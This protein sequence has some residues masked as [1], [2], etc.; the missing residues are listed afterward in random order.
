MSFNKTKLAAVLFSSLMLLQFSQGGAAADEKSGTPP[1]TPAWVF[2]H[3]VWEDDENTSDAVI[4]LLDGYA[5]Y[6]IPVGAVIIDSPWATE[7][8][9]FLWNSENYPDAQNFISNLHSRNVK[10]V[11]WMTSMLNKESDDGKYEP[12]TNSVFNE[13]MQK[14]YLTSGGRL[15]KWW[16]GLGGY[17][18]YT[19][20]QAVVWWHGLLDRVLN[21]GIDGWKCDGTDPLFP[22][23]G[24]GFSG[25]ISP[26]RY[27]EYYYMDM[28][29]H[30]VE[31]NP[32][33]ITF[34]RAVDLKI[35]NPK[36]FSPI[37]HSPSNWVGDQRHDWG[38]EGFLEALQ[39][40][41]DSAKL[42]YTVV[43]SDT[44][45]YNGDEAITKN[46]LIR[47]S[48]FS[49]LCPLFENG[50]HGA[51]QPW[52][53]DYETVQI[54]RKFVMLHKELKPYLYS[55]MMNGHLGGGPIIRVQDGKWQYMLGDSLFVSVIYEDKT[56]RDV[57][58]PAGDWIDYWDNYKTYRGGDAVNYEAP[59]DKYPLFVRGGS[60]IPLY[61]SD[62]TLGHGDQASSDAV[63]LDL[64]PGEGETNFDL[65]EEGKEKT[66]IT[67]NAA[68]GNI[69]VTADKPNGRLIIR[70]LTVKQP[71]R[72]AV[73]G[74]AIGAAD[75]KDNI[76]ADDL[77]YYY[78]VKDG[79]LWINPGRSGADKLE[80]EISF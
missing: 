10:V 74:K 44:A 33:A 18:D 40:I 39:N 49:A 36:G 67:M 76:G 14:G 13:A 1:V 56:N 57:V 2:D 55:M 53:F 70:L 4:N 62:S 47:W 3:W 48:Q 73:S 17:I 52:L 50:G 15:T 68:G 31:K 6:D 5:K 66:R 24:Y 46:L 64:Y 79:R 43:G 78:D 65:Y 7:Y 37:S 58:F 23:D 21:M 75:S 35:V 51:H 54:Y 45:G 29:S 69:T 11:L 12:K 22:S 26:K 8:N 60:I 34:S 63:T 32:Q 27:K 20:P 72:V 38:Q 19:N 80:V 25:Q 59:L 9:N 30:T 28:Y 77:K 61:V 16:K 71:A 42:G 41:F